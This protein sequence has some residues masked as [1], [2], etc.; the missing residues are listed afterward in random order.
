MDEISILRA[1][2]FKVTPYKGEKGGWNRWRIQ[3][4][5]MEK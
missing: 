1:M 4:E 3:R 2:V 5:K